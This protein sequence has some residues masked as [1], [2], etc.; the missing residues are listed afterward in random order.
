MFVIRPCPSLAVP[1]EAAWAHSAWWLYTLRVARGGG[2][3][4]SRPLREALAGQSI[5]TRPLWQ[6]LHLSPAH[7][8]AWS[9][10]CESAEELYQ[11]ALSLPCS[12]GLT[13]TDQRRVI[14]AVLDTVAR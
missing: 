12:T 8:G 4:S 14:E 6:P 7:D 9:S 11:D 1:T 5:Q 3:H 10:S 2:W 13:V